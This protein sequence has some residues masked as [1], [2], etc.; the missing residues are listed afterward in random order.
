M[1][2][3]TNRNDSLPGS[4]NVCPQKAGAGHSRRRDWIARWLMFLLCAASF[5]ASYRPGLAAEMSVCPPWEITVVDA[6]GKPVVG[7]SVMQMWGCN[8][9]E[10]YVGSKAD[11]VTDKEG[12][13]SFPARSIE[14]LAT[15]VWKKAIRKLDGKGGPDPTVGIYVSHPGHRTVWIQSRRDPRVAATRDGLRTRL[16]LEPETDKP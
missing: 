4:H 9:R 2:H 6:A 16:V 1:N 12:R 5:L 15:P 13:V 8:F 11:V 3:R 14:P 7:C 10:E